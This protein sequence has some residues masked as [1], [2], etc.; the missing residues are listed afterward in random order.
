MPKRQELRRWIA[1]RAQQDDLLYQRYGRELEPKHTGEFVAIG[2]D[3]RLVRGTDELTV[4][5]QARDLFGPGNFTI[6]R[7]GREA[8]IR[9]RRPHQ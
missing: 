3:G 8:E 4:A 5:R 6:R 7:I 1:N 2:D 9:W